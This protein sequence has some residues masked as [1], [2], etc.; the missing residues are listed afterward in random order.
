MTFAG[1][2]A[3]GSARSA[4]FGSVGVLALAIAASGSAYGQAAGPAVA[5]GD[6]GDQVVIVGQT[7]EETL[8]QELEKY[9]SDLEV[10]TSEAIRDQGFVDATTAMQMEVPGLF[11]A[12]NGG[13]FAYF[14]VSLQGSRSQD[15]LFLVDGVRLNNRLYATTLSD[16][17]PASMIERI[18]V[19]K[20]GQGLFYGTQS[21]AGVISVV[22]RGYTDDFNGVATVGGD[23]N[24]SLHLDAYARGKAGPGNFVVYASQDKSDGYEVFT[25]SQPSTTDKKRSYDVNSIGAKYRLELGDRLS[26][27]GR[28]QHTDGRLDNMSATGRAYGKN[29]RDEDLASVGLDFRATDWAQFLVKGYWHDWDSNYSTILNTIQTGTGRIIGQRV[30]DLHTYWGFED[31][32]VN[33]LAKLTPGGPFE[34]LVGYDFQQYSGK[35]D[36]LLIAEQDQDVHAVFGQI[37]S[38]DDLIENA[39]FAIGARYNDAGDSDA[40]VWNASARY[41]FADWLYAQ[42]NAGTAFLLPTAEQLFA[43]D[44]FSTLG[45]ERLEPEESTNINVGVGGA[46]SAGPSIAW[47]ATYFTRD[48]ENRIQFQD[49]DSQYV[50][51]V[52]YPQFVTDPD[53][54]TPQNEYEENGFYLNQPGAVEVRGF[55]VS[56]AADFENG[57]TANASYTNSTSED[58][59]GAQLARVPKSYAKA[60]LGYK[61][62]SGRW[63]ADV[64]LLWTGE[65]KA[66]VTGFGTVDYGDYT[67]VDIAAHL[68]VDADQKHKLTARLENAFDGD[69]SSRVGSGVIDGSSPARRFFFG[70]RGVPQTFH[71][72]YSYAF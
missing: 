59:S 12:L 18:E 65:L 36:V 15:M 49:F 40:T 11:I 24:D 29:E 7:I 22:T 67:V 56:A 13:P 61:T 21:A 63:G 5:A 44:P 9:G 54:S 16:T 10:V 27:D 17:L 8:P 45:N 55:E 14:D 26:I 35:D 70:T 47:Q 46:F 2:W 48:I 66:P 6:V 3:V 33:A 43:V 34:Y 71:L 41:D 1:F 57:L 20:G 42:A 50:F 52:L 53:P 38:T 60:G 28:Y 51:A 4:L 64:S 72:A 37:R 19:L 23:T 32:G 25:A 30:S 31:K 58:A 68:F 39:S 69:Y 62:P